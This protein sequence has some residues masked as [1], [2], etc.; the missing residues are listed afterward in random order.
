[1]RS[2]MPVVLSSSVCYQEHLTDF[3]GHSAGERQRYTE[4]TVLTC[5]SIPNCCT[6]TD[7]P[8]ISEMN[9]ERLQRKG[10]SLSELLLPVFLI[11][12]FTATR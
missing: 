4:I 2:C 8:S 6:G 9:N 3:K 12:F 10:N 5:T 11:K 1:M 7:S